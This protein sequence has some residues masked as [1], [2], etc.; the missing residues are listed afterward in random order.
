MI[1]VNSSSFMNGYFK[2]ASE[3]RSDDSLIKTSYDYWLVSIATMGT[4]LQRSGRVRE[5]LKEG[6]YHFNIGSDEGLLKNLRF[7][8]MDIPGQVEMMWEQ[9]SKNPIGDQLVQLTTPHNCEATLIGNPLFV[10]GMYFYANPSLLGLGSLQDVNSMAFLLNL[11]G[12]FTI[13]NVR[14]SFHHQSGYQVMLQ[15][16]WVARGQLRNV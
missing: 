9:A 16:K 10:P 12:Y 6:I 8:K 1:D 7:V 11:G 15:G 2:K 4:L 3:P 13:I 14:T 5:D